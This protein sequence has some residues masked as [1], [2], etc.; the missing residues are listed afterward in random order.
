[1]IRSKIVKW[2]AAGTIALA[3]VP[4]IG[5]AVNARHVPTTAAPA[6]L[7]TSAKPAVASKVSASRHTSHAKPATKHATH[8]KTTTKH[9]THRKST[10]HAKRAPARKHTRHHS[11]AKHTAVKKTHA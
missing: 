10:H 8:K 6:K 11:T 4:A 5:W 3:A 7:V 1:M 2:V 9:A